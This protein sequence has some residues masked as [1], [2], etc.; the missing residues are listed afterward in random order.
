MMGGKTV[1]SWDLSKIDLLSGLVSCLSSG[2]E[3]LDLKT[4]NATRLSAQADSRSISA[5]AGCAILGKFGT[6]WAGFFTEI[7]AFFS[8]HLT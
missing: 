5:G 8:T 7:D 6:K 3:A 1:S 4:S 2:F